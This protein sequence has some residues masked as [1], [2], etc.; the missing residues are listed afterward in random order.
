[1]FSSAKSFIVAA[2]FACAIFLMGCG[3]ENPPVDAPQIQEEVVDPERSAL[4]TC[5]TSLDCTGSPDALCCEGGGGAFYCYG[6]SRQCSPSSPCPN[7]FICEP[8]KG[9]CYWYTANCK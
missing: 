5:S 8:T 9:R 4:S 6:W 7:N 2:F 3:V 1:M